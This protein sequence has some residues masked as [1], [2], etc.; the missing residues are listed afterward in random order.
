MHPLLY[1][2]LEEEEKEGNGDKVMIGEERFFSRTITKENMGK[3]VLRDK[4]VP[5]CKEIH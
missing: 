3:G 1:R 4:D 5:F 2:W